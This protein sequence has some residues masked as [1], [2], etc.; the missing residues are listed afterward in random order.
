[1]PICSTYL[2]IPLEA[3]IVL[4]GVATVGSVFLNVYQL[5]G[6]EK[7]IGV[8]Y[9]IYCSMKFQ[10]AGWHCCNVSELHCGGN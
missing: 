7:L 5:H 3:I 10:A 8:W 6:A 4:C 2:C 1:M 9:N